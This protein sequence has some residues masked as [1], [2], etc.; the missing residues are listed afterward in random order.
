MNMHVNLQTDKTANRLLSVLSVCQCGRARFD[1]RQA[2][3]QKKDCL[4]EV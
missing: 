4:H 3:L 1:F 2:L